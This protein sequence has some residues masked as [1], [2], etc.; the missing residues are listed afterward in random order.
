M[1]AAGASSAETDSSTAL[2]GTAMGCLS[3]RVT[4]R[5]SDLV[6]HLL[7][8]AI[9][10]PRYFDTVYSLMFEKS[11]F[12]HFPDTKLGF[13]WGHTFSTPPGTHVC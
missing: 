7:Q 8:T 3:R 11:D 10:F 2:P 4:M 5:E 12:T 1:A 9:R 6:S 13:Q